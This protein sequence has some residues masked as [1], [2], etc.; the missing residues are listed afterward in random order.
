[1]RPRPAV[2][3]LACAAASLLLAACAGS[4]SGAATAAGRPGGAA[5]GPRGEIIVLAAASLTDA[6]S[7]LGARFEAANPGTKVVFSFGASSALATQIGRGAPADVYASAS[8]KT[9]DD[10]I[11]AR[12]AATSTP[13]ARNLMEIAVP[14]ANPGRITRLSDLA[15]PGVKVALCQV[16]VPCGEAAA[17]VFANAALTVRPVTQEADVKA[18][19]AKVSLGEVDAGVVY[20]TDVLAAG[21]AVTG[22]E[23]PAEVNASTTYPIAVLTAS[24]NGALAQAFVD[25]VLSAD[26]GR[27]LLGA[28]FQAP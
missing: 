7:T 24:R 4:S 13:F 23:I 18:T 9:M 22:V 3:T 6:F 5:P 17:Q 19:L 1:V 21:D 27:V 12:G 8:R 25:H 15:R 26:G 16:E 20:V 2:R 10:V 28:G 11:A 14:E